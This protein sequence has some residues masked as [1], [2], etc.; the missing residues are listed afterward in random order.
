[1]LPPAS[2]M[3]VCASV[4]INARNMKTTTSFEDIVRVCGGRGVKRTGERDVR[5]GEL[6]RRAHAKI[7]AHRKGTTQ[8]H[9]GRGCSLA[10]A[11]AKHLHEGR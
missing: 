6:G 9:A 1:M 5:E 10:A 8:A 3:T 4:R 11:R 2:V 7:T